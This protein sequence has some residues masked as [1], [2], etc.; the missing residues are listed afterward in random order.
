MKYKTCSTCGKKTRHDKRT[1]RSQPA[2]NGRKDSELE[3]VK[4]IHH[5]IQYRQYKINT[6]DDKPLSN[7]IKG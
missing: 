1:C 2:R 7:T 5:L 3:T 4:F 6:G